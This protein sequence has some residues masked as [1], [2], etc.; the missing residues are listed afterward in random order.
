VG[1]I[2]RLRHDADNTV[3]WAAAAQFSQRGVFFLIGLS[4]QAA[5]VNQNGTVA[6][7]PLVFLQTRYQLFDCRLITGD[8]QQAVL[9]HQKSE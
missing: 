1:Q 4:G 6:F 2:K 9:R 8:K 5:T 3:Q 7:K